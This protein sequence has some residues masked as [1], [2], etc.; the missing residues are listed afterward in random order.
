MFTLLKT[1]R[2]ASLCGALLLLAPPSE[3][4]PVS[5]YINGVVDSGLLAGET[6]NGKL[7]FDDALLT[8]SGPESIALSFLSFNFLSTAYY[9]ADGDFPPTADF[10]DG[11]FLG[12]SYSVSASDPLFALVSASGSGLAGDTA[13]F[14]YHSKSG[15]SGFGSLSFVAEPL[16]IALVGMGLASMSLQSRRS[17]KPL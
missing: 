14:S 16:S 5:Y 15:D 1:T 6:Y 4:A 8:H 9:I 3:A 2:A 17:K 10:Q 13:Y 7:I 11:V 12:I